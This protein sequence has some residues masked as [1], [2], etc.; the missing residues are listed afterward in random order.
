MLSLAS[1]PILRGTTW[2]TDAPFRETETA[3]NAAH[4]AGILGVEMEASALYAFAQ[5]HQRK[6]VC[7]AHITNQMGSI[8]GDFEKGEAQGSLDALD[9]IRLAT[10]ALLG[11][12]EV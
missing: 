3:I 5:A 4:A 2:T 11:E 10:Q 12:K 6:V 1:R 9:V 7:F 8:E